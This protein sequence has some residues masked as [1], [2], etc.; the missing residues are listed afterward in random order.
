M[1]SDEIQFWTMIGTWVAS[2]GTIAAVITSLFF[3]YNQNKVKLRIT[4][5]HR[6]IVSSGTE[7]TPDYCIIKV[8]NLSNKPAKIESI[9]WQAGFWRSKT[10]MIQLF[11]IPGFDDIPK[12]LTEGQDATFAVPFRLNGGKDDWIIRFPKSV[13]ETSSLNIHSLK[14]WVHIAQGQTFIAKPEKGLIDQLK[15]SLQS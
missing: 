12:V 3:A 15:R 14:L 1:T 13:T 4:V 2:F 8:V 7:G 11:G 9:G 10:S 6:Q 5:G